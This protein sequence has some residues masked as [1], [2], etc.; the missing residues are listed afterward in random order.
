MLPMDGIESHPDQFMRM[1]MGLA[2]G[3]VGSNTDA[4]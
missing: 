3:F 4:V 1:D 2:S